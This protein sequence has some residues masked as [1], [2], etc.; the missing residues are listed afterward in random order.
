MQT[1]KGTK[2]SATKWIHVGTYNKSL[3]PGGGGCVDGNDRCEMW[4]VAGEC[5]KN[6]TYM[7]NT[8]PLSCKKCQPAA[9]R[10]AALGRRGAGST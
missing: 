1:L 3:K 4:A 10:G 7:V 5:E 9:V 8:C 2:W 6:P